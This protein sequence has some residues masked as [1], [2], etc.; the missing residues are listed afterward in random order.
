[1]FCTNY[2]PSNTTTGLLSASA[3]INADRRKL[4]E[5]S[6]LQGVLLGYASVLYVHEARSLK[7]PCVRLDALARASGG[8]LLD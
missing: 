6:T 8:S 5:P 2:T 1:M 7:S 4:Q 3:T